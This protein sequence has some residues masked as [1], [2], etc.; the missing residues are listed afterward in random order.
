MTDSN[1]NQTNKRPYECCNGN[2]ECCDGNHECCDGN[3]ECCDGTEHI[4]KKMKTIIEDT[5]Q[6]TEDIRFSWWGWS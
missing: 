1:Q 6:K 2:H 4:S 3:H 5:S